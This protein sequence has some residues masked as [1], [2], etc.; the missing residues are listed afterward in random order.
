MLARP[1]FPAVL[2]CCRAA[3]VA[4]ELIEICPVAVRASVGFDQ[5]DQS[6]Q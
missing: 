4:N 6:V 2:A 3:P 1:R 5:D